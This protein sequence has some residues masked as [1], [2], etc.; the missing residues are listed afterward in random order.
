[1]SELA[2]RIAGLSPEKR[3]LLEERLLRGAAA[4][5]GAGS[6]ARRGLSR[7]PLSFAQQ[8]LWFLDQLDP[9]SSL[10]NVPEELS[11]R[12]PLDVAA[13]EHALQA[14]V[15]RHEVLRTSFIEENGQVEARVEPAQI[16]LVV[17]DLQDVPEGRR[18]AE[19][20]AIA[21]AEAEVPF[22][23]RKAPLFRAR[24]LRLAPERHWLLLTLH[25]IVS[26]EW[27]MGVL[28]AELSELYAA[29]RAGR[30]VDVKPL[31]IQY[32]DYALWQREWLS[33]PLRE[34]LVSYWKRKLAGELPTLALPL[35]RPRSPAARSRGGECRRPIRGQA[36]M[37][38]LGALCKSEGVTPFMALLAAYFVLLSRYAGQEDVLVGTPIAGRNRLETE[39]LIGFFVNTLVLRGDLSADPTFRRF[40]GSVRETVLEAFTNQELPFEV[41]VEELR[42][43]RTRAHSPLFQAMFELDEAPGARLQLDGLETE[44]VELPDTSAKF[45]LRLLVVMDEEGLELVFEY[46]TE[47][48]DASTI[49]RLA[50]NYET[51]LLEALISPDRPVSWLP[52]LSE[53]ERRQVLVDWNRTDAD[54]PRDECV[55]R[56]FQEQAARTPEAIAVTFADESL[57]YAE[58]DR[59]SS[60]LAEHLQQLGV[61]PD[62]LVGLCVPRSPE[63]L[64]GVLGVLKAGGA[65][66]P[67][68]PT[69]PAHRLA[70]MLGDSGARVLVTFDAIRD[71]LPPYSGKM[72]RLDA[73]SRIIFG[74]AGT[75]RDTG[76]A[77]ENLAYVIYTSGSTGQ[78]KG[79]MV[80]HRCLVNYV[81]WCIAAYEVASGSGAPLHSSLSFD[82]TVTGLF[83]PLLCGRCVSLLPEGFAAQALGGM[84]THEGRFSLVKITPT[85]FDMLEGEIEAAEAAGCSRS[86]VI[87]GEPLRAESLTFWRN[88]APETAIYNEYGPTETTVG[89]SVYEVRADDPQTGPVSI[90]RPIS[91]TRLYVLDRHREPVP[92]GVVG[93]L[94]VGGD[95]VARGY[96]KRPELTAE[97]FVEDP[98]GGAGVAPLPH[99]GPG[100]VPGR[101]QSRLSRTL[102][103]SGQDSWLSGGAGGDRGGH[104]GA[105]FRGRGR[106]RPPGRGSGGPEARWI[107]RREGRRVVEPRYHS[108]IAAR[109]PSGL[110]GAIGR[111]E[112]G[113][114][115]GDGEREARSLGP[116]ASGLAAPRHR[117]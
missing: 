75:V 57:T 74:R 71:S 5:A 48:F 52:I 59:R 85:R 32:G 17:S 70:N 67:L 46:A 63:M 96:W 88:N 33:G 51:L 3:A 101:R 98:F 2:S 82:L 89:C 90:G 8:R 103:R 40:L 116:P 65:Y 9:G 44:P 110:H 28:Y 38:A 87:G 94:F 12:G 49:A 64:V 22:D 83:G 34:R 29:A 81:S 50:A 41:L 20:E 36:P 58:L 39:R 19:A 102:R 111:H 73:D 15:D 24:L 13:L 69:Y 54:Y 115:A 68:D 106:S 10:Y 60:Q 78:P 92:I 43:E 105:S 35:D 91:N 79:V 16:R 31:A 95:G 42:P 1:M 97:R 62:I 93:E 61:G 77:P 26:D 6:I 76:V 23:L 66:V 47:L 18:M 4:R 72:V 100:A 80:P 11:I 104:A 55:H 37:E 114:A 108:P 7:A 30:D 117:R 45:D 56:L 25:H 99:G 84:L 14:I 53:S 113:T 27:S 21:M 107:R 112:A 86:F 109:P